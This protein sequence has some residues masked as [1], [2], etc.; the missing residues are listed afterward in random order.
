LARIFCAPAPKRG[1]GKKGN[2]RKG[3]KKRLRRHFPLCGRRQEGG[4]EEEGWKEKKKGKSAAEIVLFPAG[5]I[6]PGRKKKRKRARKKR[7]KR[8]RRASG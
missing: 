4:K 3:G 6:G 2:L 1:E 5:P 8:G 7:K